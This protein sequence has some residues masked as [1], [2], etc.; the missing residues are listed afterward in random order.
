MTGALLHSPAMRR[1]AYRVSGLGLIAMGLVGA[2]ARQSLM[3]ERTVL[4]AVTA[5]EAAFEVRGRNPPTA[6][7]TYADH[8]E[9]FSVRVLDNAY[10][11]VASASRPIFS[12]Q[13]PGAP[14]GYV[15]TRDASGCWRLPAL[16]HCWRQPNGNHR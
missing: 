10:P 4:A 15:L 11:D 14:I 6:P 12:Q 1:A 13:V 5:G 8:R 3:C 16:G 2:G 7:T 9:T